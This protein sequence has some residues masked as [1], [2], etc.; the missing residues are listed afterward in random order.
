MFGVIAMKW[1]NDMKYNSTIDNAEQKAFEHWFYRVCPSGD[2][3]SVHAQ[4]L[5]SSDWEDFNLEHE[6]GLE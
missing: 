5:E 1:G 6:E 2:C 4:W 3:D